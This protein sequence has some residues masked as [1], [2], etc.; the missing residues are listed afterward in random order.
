MAQEAKKGVTFSA[1]AG[2]LWHIV[3]EYSGPAAVLGFAYA[4]SQAP[5]ELAPEMVFGLGLGGLAWVLNGW[6]RVGRIE[7][8]RQNLDSLAAEQAKSPQFFK[9]LDEIKKLKDKKEQEKAQQIFFAKVAQ[10][11]GTTDPEAVNAEYQQMLVINKEIELHKKNIKEN[12]GLR[13]LS[14]VARESSEAALGGICTVA[15]INIT[16]L[17]ISHGIQMDPL[18][19]WTDAQTIAWLTRRAVEFVP[20]LRFVDIAVQS[21]YNVFMLVGLQK[22]LK[23]AGILKEPEQDHH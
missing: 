7:N 22:V 16:R 10:A 3:T 15:F 23:D 21:R 20:F 19:G 13:G 9:M 1:F 17:M 12:T 18:P 5:N 6:G 2:G 11:I 4:A 14:R 8:S